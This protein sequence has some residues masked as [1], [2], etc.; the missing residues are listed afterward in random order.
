MEGYNSGRH[1]GQG[2][3]HYPRGLARDH[4]RWPFRLCRMYFVCIRREPWL[5]RNVGNSI[6]GLSHPSLHRRPRHCL[7]LQ[8]RNSRR[9][10]RPSLLCF[11]SIWS[12]HME[13]TLLWAQT[14]LVGLA[15]RH[16]RLYPHLPAVA[17]QGLRR[18]SLH[19]RRG[20]THL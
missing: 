1:R 14:K 12:I 4:A 20:S 2:E 19:P 13:K 3:S 18:R 8:K 9:R 11:R 6:N 7:R 16:P 10:S 17:P 15:L 5:H